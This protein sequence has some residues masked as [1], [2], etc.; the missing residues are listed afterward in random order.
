MSAFWCGCINQSGGDWSPPRYE[1]RKSCAADRLD[2]ADASRWTGSVRRASR[3][4]RAS[5]TLIPTSGAMRSWASRRCSR[6]WPTNGYQG[7]AITTSTC[8][9]SAWAGS[10][11][12]PQHRNQSAAGGQDAQAKTMKIPGTTWVAV[13]S[14]RLAHAE[15]RRPR[16]P[17]ELAAQHVRVALQHPGLPRAGATVPRKHCWAPPT[18]LPGR[19]WGPQEASRGRS[20]GMQQRP[21][22]S[23][24]CSDK[25]TSAFEHHLPVFR[26]ACCPYTWYEKNDLNTSDVPLHP[27]LS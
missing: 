21:K 26:H 15:L 23:W 24:I 18:A 2:G 12:A 1:P 7:S 4:P 5:S 17:A 25:R 11:S 13:S 6:R 27:P 22:A 9:P 20:S 8:A 3:T 16:Q 19:T 14:G 10:P